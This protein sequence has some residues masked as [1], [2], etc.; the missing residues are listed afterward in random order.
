MS[1][2]YGDTSIVETS[3]FL[4]CISLEQL[5]TAKDKSVDFPFSFLLLFFKFFTSFR[6]VL[7]S[8][9]IEKDMHRVFLITLVHACPH[10]C[11]PN[12]VVSLWPL[13]NTLTVIMQRL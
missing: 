13:I 9:A 1:V 11:L 4:T 12:G 2:D 6:A 10:Y 8:Y 5:G 7:S 3:L